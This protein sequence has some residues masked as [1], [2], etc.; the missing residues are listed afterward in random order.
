MNGHIY[1]IVT[2]KEAAFSFVLNDVIEQAGHE[3]YY[4]KE[5][6]PKD[7][8][9][10][11]DDLMKMMNK[12]GAE[13]G[14]DGGVPYFIM[15]D[16][17]RCNY[18]KQRFERFTRLASRVKCVADFV[19]ASK[20]GEIANCITNQLGDFV[21]RNALENIDDWFRNAENNTKYYVGNVIYIHY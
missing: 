11:V 1:E 19:S 12:Y 4:C 8:K 10:R 7:I 20:M 6:K 21:Y 2:E 13:T 9:E 3:F 15:S 14:F 16:T 17:V 18:F 5:I